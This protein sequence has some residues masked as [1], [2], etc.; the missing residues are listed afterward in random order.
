MLAGLQ[1]AFRPKQQREGR[2]PAW[3]PLSKLGGQDHSS[4]G[5]RLADEAAVPR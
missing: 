1:Q 5:G 4:V 3:L 2:C